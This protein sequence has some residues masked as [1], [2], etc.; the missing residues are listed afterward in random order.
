MRIDYQKSGQTQEAVTPAQVKMRQATAPKRPVLRFLVLV[1]VI[2]VVAYVGVQF[3]RAGTIHTYGLV[4]ADSTPYFAP[5]EGR[6]GEMSLE[7]GQLV[8]EGDVLFTLS[9]T[10][11]ETV[12]AAQDMLLSEIERLNQ[13]AV[14]LKTNI[15][16]QARKEV[17]YLEAIHREENIRRQAAEST[18]EI[19]L[20]KLRNVY[21][22][23]K[24]R[25]DRVASLFAM[26]AAIQSDVDLTR[27]RADLAYHNW[28]Q[29]QLNLR[30]AQEQVEESGAALEKA[31]LELQR[32][33]E[34]RTE[35]AN[36]LALG[37][38]KLDVAQT[39]PDVLSV[40]SLFNGIVM[41][42]GA[43]E[44]SRVETGRIITTIAARDSIWIEAYVPE[45]DARF[46]QPGG[47][48]LIQLP[49]DRAWIP[50][51]I[52]NQYGTT[53]SV[54]ERLQDD[55]PG[56]QAGIYVRINISLPDGDT[57]IPGGQVRVRIP[58]N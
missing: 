51:T 2:A 3:S 29:A 19:E 28:R 7:R 57:I 55:L 46:V 27:E 36:V 14:R 33:M 48:A 50:A 52:A 54:P 9:P 49:G 42:V 16:E 43:V 4:T 17:E 44:E 31:R 26:G 11:S 5:F 45:K 8:L 23:R 38:L 6:I 10:P 39:R 20:L 53:M 1:A 37:K 24:L 25:A 13:Q 58:K 56:Q 21:D 22:S 47:E 35:D 40:R 41:Q 34:E 18:A 30:V 12:R 32:V 15:V